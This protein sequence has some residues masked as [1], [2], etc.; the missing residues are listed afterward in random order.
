MSPVR[1]GPIS[2]RDLLPLLKEL[3][4]DS[5]A[6][7]SSAHRDL[8]RSKLREILETANV[9]TPFIM[10]GLIG[11]RARYLNSIG[12]WVPMQYHYG[13]WNGPKEPK[14]DDEG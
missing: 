12:F 9:R 6:G 11:R 7:S 13:T 8:A 3:I 10:H 1:K 4:D 14:V 2:Q 5:M